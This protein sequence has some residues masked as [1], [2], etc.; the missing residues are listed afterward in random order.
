MAN[1][2]LSYV[3]SVDWNSQ[4][5]LCVL[6]LMGSPDDFRKQKVKRHLLVSVAQLVGKSLLHGHRVSRDDL[7]D[8][9]L[10]YSVAGRAI[11]QPMSRESVDFFGSTF[12]EEVGSGA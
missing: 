2:C 7:L 9:T 6:V 11:E 4:K 5:L 1:L 8:C 3:T 10:V 12:V